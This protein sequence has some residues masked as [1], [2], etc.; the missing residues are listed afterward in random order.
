MKKRHLRTVW[1][2]ASELKDE[3]DKNAHGSVPMCVCDPDGGVK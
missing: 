3:N 2:S 1:K